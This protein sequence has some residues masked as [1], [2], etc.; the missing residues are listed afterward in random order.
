MRV[1]LDLTG[2][3]FGK[4]LVTQ[5]G[6]NKKTDVR[7]YTRWKTVCD[8]GTEKVVGTANLMR[9][10][11]RSCGCGQNRTPPVGYG[12]CKRPLPPGI[13]SRN[14]VYKVYVRKAK[15]RNYCWEISNETFDRLVAGD[16]H[17]C[18]APPSN[19][20][21]L[22]KTS[23]FIYNGIDRVDNTQGYVETN[24]VSCCKYCNRA[25]SDMTYTEFLNYVRRIFE[26]HNSG[27]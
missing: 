3:R 18:E 6:E 10:Y 1:P 4:L 15:A 2:R 26:R 9:G 24:V 19:S 5:R 17:Y 7:S 20:I 11:S 27:F 16:C 23:R 12:G 21:Q 22:G 25:K 8:C 13:A 14:A